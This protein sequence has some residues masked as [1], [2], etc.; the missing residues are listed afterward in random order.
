MLYIQRNILGSSYINNLNTLHFTSS[1][2]YHR[3]D[4]PL[5]IHFQQYFMKTTSISLV[6]NSREDANSSAMPGP[7]IT[8][9]AL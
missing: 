6:T 9:L 8:I 4:Y 2:V 1:K 3:L 7:S 5:Q